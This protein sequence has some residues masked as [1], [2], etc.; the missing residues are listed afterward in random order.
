MY[1]YLQGVVVVVL[2][3]LTALCAAAVLTYAHR[4]RKHYVVRMCQVLLCK[5]LLLGCTVLA[6]ATVLHLEAPTAALC[7]VRPLLQHLAITVILGCMTTKV[8]ARFNLLQ[9]LLCTL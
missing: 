2:A 3:V 4:R 9:T 8:R 5:L 1:T 7:I 6:A